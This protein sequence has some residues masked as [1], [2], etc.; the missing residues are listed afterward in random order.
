[1]F[2]RNRRSDS[3]AQRMGRETWIREALRELRGESGADRCGVW[4]EA[5]RGEERAA[6]VCVFRGEV[7]DS[8][9][10]F[11]AE[12]WSRL[13]LEP[14]L[15]LGLLAMGRTAEFGEGEASH[16]PIA[17]PA[18][19]M[20]HGFWIPVTA[21]GALRGVLLLAAQSAATPL[22]R[23]RAEEIAEELAMALEWE[24]QQ[25]LAAVRKSDLEFAMHI[26]QRLSGEFEADALFAEIVN[27]CTQR[28]PPPGI[29]AVFALIGERRSRQ[30][31]AA[32]S[33][34]RAAERLEI[35]ALSGDA[36]WGHSVEQGPLEMFW[37]QAVETYQMTGAE[38]GALPLARG[39]AR[40]VALPLVFAGQAHGVLLAGLPHGLGSAESMER[41]EHRASLAA[42][43]LQQKARQAEHTELEK[44]QQALLESSEQPVLLVDGGGFLRGLSRGARVVLA[45]DAAACAV[46]RD[47]PVVRF[48]E[49][50][51]PREWERANQW[52]Q[53][54]GRVHGDRDASVAC[55]AEGRHGGRM[56]A[57]GTF[58]RGVSGRFPGTRPR[59]GC[60]TQPGGRGRRAAPGG[61][62]DGRRRGAV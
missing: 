25:R 15:P 55:A 42:Q 31:V 29:G 41:L 38:A 43:A 24:E 59:A 30:A 45:R 6:G 52:R 12:G 3:S 19:G 4:L 36:A 26:H 60:K 23:A 46:R 13:S 40:I 20:A 49:L 56:P 57:P 33:G 32:P 39:I 34:A 18:M 50:F 2:A 62:L 28:E 22:P 7:F 9:E 1:M 47:K 17:G 54:G 35:R 10:S 21:M 5:S 14:P 51:R 37:R 58:R 27:S 16:G 8:G 53:A 61:R 48:A 44:W 11:S